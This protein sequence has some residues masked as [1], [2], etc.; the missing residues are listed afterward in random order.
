[1]VE[2]GERLL[3]LLLL[4]HSARRTHTH[5]LQTLHRF[6]RAL[7]LMYAYEKYNPFRIEK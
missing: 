6:I 4:A 3:L 1:M 7:L 2:E 5:F